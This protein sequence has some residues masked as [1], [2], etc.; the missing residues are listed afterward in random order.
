MVHVK[1]LIIVS[2]LIITFISSCTDTP[3]G[4]SDDIGKYIGNWNVSDQSARINY[5]VS[6]EPN[7]SNSTEILMNN[8]AGLGS[9]AVALVVGNSLVIDSQSLSADYTVSG[10]GTY[11]NSSKLV[12]NFELNDG[13]DSEQR[14][15]T[16][17]R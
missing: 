14:I 16:F 6:I 2:A 12:V 8:F 1:Y 11:V 5:S 4:G 10:S 15:A 3:T 13:I 17:T 9:T 7:P